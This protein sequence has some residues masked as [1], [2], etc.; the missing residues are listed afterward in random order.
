MVLLYLNYGI[1]MRIGQ[2]IELEQQADQG[3]SVQYATTVDLGLGQPSTYITY[4]HKAASTPTIQVNNGGQIGLTVNTPITW[5]NPT[6][7]V[8]GGHLAS[9]PGSTTFSESVQ[10][11]KAFKL[12]LGSSTVPAP[13]LAAEIHNANW[14]IVSSLYSI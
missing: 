11:V 5:S 13:N 9:G 12:H 3:G 1:L 6:K 10:Y 2:S 4:A 8:I 14:A 7:W